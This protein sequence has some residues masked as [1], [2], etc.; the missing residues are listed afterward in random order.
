M[1]EKL[2]QLVQQK[3]NLDNKNKELELQNF[4][5]TL[6]DILIKLASRGQTFHKIYSHQKSDTT[7]IQPNGIDLNRLEKMLKEKYPD[8]SITQNKNCNNWEHIEISWHE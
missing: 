8:L 7:Y 5:N 4:V 2:Q 3:I 1:R 6:D